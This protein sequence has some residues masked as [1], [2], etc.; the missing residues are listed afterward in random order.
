MNHQSLRPE[1]RPVGYDRLDEAQRNAFNGLVHLISGAIDAL[2]VP[3]GLARPTPV[4][5]L[6]GSAPW[7]D[8]DRTSRLALLHGDRGIGKTTVLLSLIDA[9]I[10]THRAGEE[11]KLLPDIEGRLAT[12][13][14]RTLW[15]EP[16]DMATLP[17]PANLL[18]AILAR[19]EEVARAWILP[20]STECGEAEEARGGLL[21]IHPDYLGPLQTLQRLQMSVAIAWDGNLPERQGQLDPDSFAVEAMRAERDRQSFNLNLAQ[22]L[23]ALAR[24]IF[25]GGGVT[26]PLFVVSVD[27]VDLNPLRCLETLRLIQMI[28]VP[29]LFAIVLGHIEVIETVLNLKYSGD[30]A[31]LLSHRARL[32]PLSMQANHVAFI[33]GAVSANALRKLLPPAQRIG[34]RGMTVADTLNFQPLGASAPRFHALL[35]RFP[36]G[37]ASDSEPLMAGKSIYSLRDFLLY[38]AHESLSETEDITKDRVDQS[39]YRAKAMLKMPPRWVADSW[40][41]LKEAD[42]RYPIDPNYDKEK[43]AARWG[44]QEHRDKKWN[45]LVDLLGR[46]TRSMIDEDPSLSPTDRRRFREGLRRSPTSGAWEL[47]FSVSCLPETESSLNLR[48][49]NLNYPFAHAVQFYSGE[50]W[51]LCPGSSTWPSP[52]AVDPI[53]LEEEIRRA[54][55]RSFSANTTS[56]LVLLHDLLM[57]KAREFSQPN[58]WKYPQV[59]AYTDWRVSSSKATWIRWPAPSFMSF[60]EFDIFLHYWNAA[61]EARLVDTKYFVYFWLDAG[62][63]VMLRE[64]PL[65]AA[66]EQPKLDW[67]TLTERLSTLRDKFKD[68]RDRRG[69]RAAEWLTRLAYFLWP[70]VS[71]IDKETAKYILSNQT[72]A[73]FWKQNLPAIGRHVVDVFKPLESAGLKSYDLDPLKRAWKSYIDPSGEPF[74]TIP[75]PNQPK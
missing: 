17:G 73:E 55:E 26:D 46:H 5:R 32:N 16:I 14:G 41:F 10:R 23:E 53:Q 54:L 70:A 38:P 51:R 20:A 34:L 8:Y 15:L 72:L 4:T 60:W 59:L 62:A 18:V 48:I 21:E 49:N 33:V 61:L 30:F 27:D 3:E 2:K 65:R 42:D 35:E 44:S 11:V 67:E 9:C 6:A 56:A 12:P 7:L 43:S 47:S 74:K 68:R 40:F 50:G 66:S 45:E 19:I 25:R 75:K 29:R 69:G 36:A 37:I 52:I 39:Y 28:S 64:N 63:A 24:C 22:C 71:G 13:R 57:F 1:P 31:S 58:L